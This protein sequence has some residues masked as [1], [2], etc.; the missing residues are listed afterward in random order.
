MISHIILTAIRGNPF[1]AGAVR[2][3]DG[4]VILFKTPEGWHISPSRPSLRRRPVSGQMCPALLLIF[5]YMPLLQPLC[6]PARGFIP[7]MIFWRNL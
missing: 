3:S 1:S 7:F 4:S 5:P 2:I 6:F